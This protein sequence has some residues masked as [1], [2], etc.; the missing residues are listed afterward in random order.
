M[1]D[2]LDY[3]HYGMNMKRALGWLVD[4]LMNIS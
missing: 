4:F 3:T 1:I 2:W